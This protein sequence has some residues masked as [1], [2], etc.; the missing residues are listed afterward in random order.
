MSRSM[1]LLFCGLL[2]AV[3]SV[4]AFFL[5]PYLCVGVVYSF[6]VLAP[7]SRMLGRSWP[8]TLGTVALGCFGYPVAVVVMTF[9]PYAACLGGFLGTFFMLAEMGDETSER[10][11]L[12][13]RRTLWAGSLAPLILTVGIFTEFGLASALVAIPVWQLATTLTLA[14]AFEPSESMNRVMQS[15]QPS[16]PN[17]G[18]PDINSMERT[19]TTG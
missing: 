5:H 11:R 16:C 9:S 13:H 10:V 18:D 2:S 4:P 7:F 3:L 6:L 19:N 15:D 1:T 17:S 14:T 12:A 8:S